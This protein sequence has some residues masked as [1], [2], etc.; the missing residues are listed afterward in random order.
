MLS[1]ASSFVPK[2][3]TENTSSAITNS[4]EQT[5]LKA[6]QLLQRW[7][8]REYP[9]HL[10]RMRKK[11]FFL[12]TQA[13]HHF[14]DTA[15]ALS[16][17]KTIAAMQQFLG[18]IRRKAGEFKLDNT[19]PELIK[20]TQTFMSA[21]LFACHPEETLDI[22]ITSE[23]ELYDTACSL[24]AAYRDLR[25]LIV[26]KNE[27]E[28]VA[29][30]V[31]LMLFNE[32]YG[33]YLNIFL[34][35]QKEHESRLTTSCIDLYV[36]MEVHKLQMGTTIGSTTQHKIYQAIE[37]SQSHIK[38]KLGTQALDRL[39][40]KLEGLNAEKAEKIND[41]FCDETMN[42]LYQMMSDPN[43]KFSPHLNTLETRNAV[44]KIASAVN[45]LTP[46]Y[47]VVIAELLNMRRKISLL[48]PH[49]GRFRQ[50][51]REELNATDLK[52]VVPLLNN[53]EVFATSLKYITKV[54]Q[55]LQSSIH[56]EGI[57][58]W[59]E[60][61]LSDAE[62]G[63]NPLRLLPEIFRKIYNKID[64]IAVEKKNFVFSM[65]KEFYQ[66]KAVKLAQNHF[67]T[68]IHR[69]ELDLDKTDKW[70]QATVEDG[71]NNGLSREM[72]CSNSPSAHFAI[73][74]MID[75]VLSCNHLSR[76]SCPE[77]LLP[78]RKQLNQICQQLSIIKKIAIGYETYCFAIKEF[79][80]ELDKGF[81]QKLTDFVNHTPNDDLAISQF[82]AQHLPHNER[83]VMERL[84]HSCLNSD[85]RVNKLAAQKLREALK[86]YAY[87]GKLPQHSCLQAI[88]SF[89]KIAGKLKKIAYF[90]HTIHAE[91]YG[92]KIKERQWG[93]LFKLLGKTKPIHSQICPVLLENE[94]EHLNKL[95]Q[96]I[97]R[98]AHLAT[99]LTFL[100]Q[101]IWFSDK[102]IEA[103]N[104]SDKDFSEILD[105]FHLKEI[106][107][108]DESHE[109][110]YHSNIL[111][112]EEVLRMKEIHLDEEVMEKTRK[113][114]R[115]VSS[116]KNPA[117]L[118][119]HT[120]IVEQIKDHAIGKGNKHAIN[121]TLHSF[122][123]EIKVM[124]KNLSDIMER[125]KKEVGSVNSPFVPTVPIICRSAFACRRQK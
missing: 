10:D 67:Y 27:L 82:I 97:L 49:N 59:M 11:T 79:Q 2:L 125:S 57:R 94:Q 36:R 74:A 20:P 50:E 16:C 34:E 39:Y 43:F 100:R 64:E 47:S 86:L 60:G 54:L 44:K 45:S 121:G 102:S 58:D 80:G 104:L 88:T 69:Y 41:I 109:E 63:N 70:I 101:Q 124:G 15:K 77:T 99:A 8:R 52:E 25:R 71:Q 84:I 103:G 107:N 112:F 13:E 30:R 96:K 37:K 110:I 93:D 76:K 4:N 21:F 83:Q 73:I 33:H 98:M 23:Q 5:C 91:V 81:I 17:H 7:W 92:L 42:V 55:S 113:M 108:S 115:N 89:E 48:V 24:I 19:V 90:N 123:F 66:S 18:F 122:M 56:D 61:I 28:K 31:A 51:L 106:L 12:D 53:P 75:Q 119:F 114:L 29:F 62:A 32:R 85:H 117:F 14:N 65:Y 22:Q 105:Q 6:A 78:E 40:Q 1:I 116:F 120:Q 35:R 26:P 68:R 111:M 46:N 72:L 3:L 118:T 87:A 9:S 95:H 38:S